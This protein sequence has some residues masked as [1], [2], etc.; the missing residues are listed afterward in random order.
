MLFWIF[1]WF[2]CGFIGCAIGAKKNWGCLGA[3]LGFLLG[4]I[5]II[6][7]LLVDPDTK[8]IE[9]EKIKS[10]ESKK[11]PYCAE[12]IKSE[13]IVCR[14]CGKEI[15]KKSS[16]TDEKKDVYSHIEPDNEKQGNKND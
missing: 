5:G 10:G 4:P 11:C 7:I 1:I 14:Y 15:I 3:I 12:L 16:S 6:I 2:L 13:A 9:E 8:S